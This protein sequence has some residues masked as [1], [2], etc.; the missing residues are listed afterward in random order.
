MT[1]RIAAVRIRT[2]IL[3]AAALA[4]TATAA[5]AVSPAVK[6]ACANDY[7]AYC[8][9]HP[10]G[11]KALRR[12]MRSAGPRLS[13]RCVNALVAAGEVSKREVKRR[14]AK[15]RASKKRRRAASFDRSARWRR[16]TIH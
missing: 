7:F 15:Y 1:S 16:G 5:A 3:A 11:T 12:C 9:K 13:K 4:I 10:V 14:A 2:G 6:R 8:S